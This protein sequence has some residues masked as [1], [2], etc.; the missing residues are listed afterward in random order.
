MVA[1]L[2]HKLNITAEAAFDI[3][4]VLELTWLDRRV[5]KSEIEYYI[6][7]M[8]TSG[9]L[10]WWGYFR[11]DYVDEDTGR[12]LKLFINKGGRAGLMQFW[13][14]VGVCEAADW[15]QDAED[16]GIIRAWLNMKIEN[17]KEDEDA[18]VRW[19]V[20]E[21]LKN[22]TR[23]VWENVLTEVLSDFNSERDK[24]SATR[25]AILQSVGF[26]TRRRRGAGEKNNRRGKRN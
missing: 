24:A 26:S 22:T 2:I 5:L 8:T 19:R 12:R 7:H 18:V 21:L 15:T 3:S 9:R 17:I 23:T 11:C 13:D 1:D 10:P 4:E 16:D 14:L 25:V 20:Q 6:S